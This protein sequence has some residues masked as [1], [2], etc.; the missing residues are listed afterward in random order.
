V[1]IGSWVSVALLSV[2]VDTEMDIVDVPLPVTPVVGIVLVA[3]LIDSV[4]A[5][6]PVPVPVDP[7]LDI[8]DVAIP[9]PN[10]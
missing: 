1:P 8:V 4:V 5:V 6:V 2:P 3:G 9:V 7:E 10:V